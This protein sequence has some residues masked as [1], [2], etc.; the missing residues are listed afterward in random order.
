MNGPRA[1][2]G[3]RAQDALARARLARLGRR[4]A[5]PKLVR[6][7]AEAHPRAVFVEIGSNDGAQHDHLRPFILG[8]PWSGVMVEPVPYVFDRLRENYGRLDRVALENVAVAE[9]DGARPFYHLVDA[10]PEERRALPSW[11]DGIGSFSRAAVLGHAR[12]IPDIEDRL[13]CTPVPT[14]TFESLCEKHGLDRVDLLL[15][16]TEG[17]DWEIV[18]RIDFSVRRPRVLVYEHFHL[19]PGDRRDCL[20]HL[21]GLGYE[22]LEEGFDTFCLDPLADALTVTWS[23]LRAAL[24]GVSVHEEVDL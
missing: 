23:G 15:V 21:R 16:D 18:R 8:R 7:F 12:H 6:A 14:L 24:P 4:L 3:R 9:R 19:S 13:V 1:R 10:S 2:L 11:Y 22:T 5:G 17:H 20:A